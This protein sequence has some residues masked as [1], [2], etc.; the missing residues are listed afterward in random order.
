LGVRSRPVERYVAERHNVSME[1]ELGTISVKVKYLGG[2]AV[3]AAPEFE[4]CRRLAEE[5]AVPLKKVLEEATFTFWRESGTQA[6]TPAKK[7]KRR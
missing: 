1:T 7:G 6:G 2:M 3:G 4:D 5:N